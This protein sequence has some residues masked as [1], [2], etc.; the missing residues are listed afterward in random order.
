MLQAWKSWS[1]GRRIAVSGVFAAVVIQLVPYGRGHHNP[2]VVAEPAWDA[3]QTRELA[4]RRCFDCHSNE[5]RWPW[6][7][8]IAP[9]SW[10][11]QRHVDE[12]R[13]DLNFSEWNR[14]QHDTW[15]TAVRTRTGD[16]P[17]FGYLALHPEARMTPA[18]LNRLAQGLLNTVAKDPPGG[19][20][21]T[22]N[23][24]GDDEHS[25]SAADRTE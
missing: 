5:T 19:G 15:E 12:G 20:A 17:V 1:R 2:A 13:S 6:Y 21:L 4:V 8:A 18:E 3:P 22:G 7:A 9:I 14:P 10:L 24:S 25:S 11:V 16:M 23:V